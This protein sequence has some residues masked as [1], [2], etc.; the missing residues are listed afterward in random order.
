MQDVL[1]TEIQPSTAVEAT[2]VAYG[3][4]DLR[5]PDEVTTSL[6]LSLSLLNVC[7]LRPFTHTRLF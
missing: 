1:V 4:I 5:K 3:M 6:S 7:L 2:N